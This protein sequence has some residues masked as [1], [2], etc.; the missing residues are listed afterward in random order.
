MG[1][2]PAKA[3]QP[4]GWSLPAELPAALR[5][6]KPYKL[7]QPIYNSLR[8][9]KNSIEQIPPIT[10]LHDAL[11]AH[12]SA[13]IAFHPHTLE[14]DNTERW[15]LYALPDA[16]L[17]TS[18]LPH[19]LRLWLTASYGKDRAQ[20]I[21][22]SW[23]VY[24]WD[25]QPLIDLQTADDRLKKMLLPGLVAR[26]IKEQAFQ[27]TLHGKSGTLSLP[28]NLVQ[29]MTE[30]GTA[31]LIS[32]PQPFGTAQGSFVL[33]F[34]IDVRPH[35]G[36][37]S[38]LYRLSVRRWVTE[39]LV[40]KNNHVLLPL[41]RNK[42]VYL[43]NTTRYLDHYPPERVYSRMHFRFVSYHGEKLRWIGHQAALF[44]QL[45]LD[46]I[47]TPMEL[48]ADPVAHSHRLL[49]TYNRE[50]EGL[51]K[52]PRL[53]T[54]L[55]ANDHRQTFEDL[56]AFLAPDF[57]PL[58]TGKR[59]DAGDGRVWRGRSL[60]QMRGRRSDKRLDA[61]RRLP[62]APRIELYVD[63]VETVQKILLQLL[64]ASTIA[65]QQGD[66]IQVMDGERLLL[67]VT[68]CRDEKLTQPLDNGTDIRNLIQKRRKELASRYQP[69]SPP[70]GALVVLQDY[71]KERQKKYD[72][73][74]AIRL[75]LADSGRVSQFLTP[76]TDEDTPVTRKNQTSYE[77]RVI[78]AVRDLLR[79]LGYRLNALYTPVAQL[80]L[81]TELDLVGF[82]VIQLNKRRPDQ[83][84]IKLPLMI[85]ALYQNPNFRITLPTTTGR[86]HDYPSLCEGL[87]AAAQ[88][89]QDYAGI[90]PEFFFREAF[91]R[92]NSQ[93]PTLLLLPEQNL[94]RFFPELDDQR[95]GPRI[96][97]GGLL[98]NQPHVRVARLRKSADLEAPYCVSTTKMSRYQG[99]YESELP[100]VFYSLHN[101]V[102]RAKLEDYKL[103][104]AH[105]SAA[106]PSTLQI[107]MNNLPVNESPAQ[108]AALVH[109]LRRESSH[110]DIPTILPQ[111]LHDALKVREYLLDAVFETD[112]EDDVEEN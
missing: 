14:R 63:D 53:E 110:T 112:D 84:T 13:I 68:V 48:L 103:D 2:P 34:W 31:E 66:H 12:S 46:P 56:S 104:K 42:S 72:P 15:W 107:Y 65:T 105:Q 52:R 40:G 88:L 64:G 90:T 54:G 92:R 91:F 74:Q 18:H 7:P 8:A 67:E 60:R 111:P 108:W 99:L 101:L 94:R 80:D 39:P 10:S 20:S 29:L 43:R 1:S 106:T 85:E 16:V 79:V 71:R 4:L 33:R 27:L 82:Y 23:G 77:L 37:L 86:V 36:E 50:P 6:V 35:T 102:R 76:N 38:L 25:D 81:P 21:I 49:I 109:R 95:S 30:R 11:A 9:L 97:L 32:E 57:K 24:E 69:T 83:E 17:K 62:S 100:D 28:L 73:K 93:R 5:Y 51:G 70:T 78:Q 96:S 55:H 26:W 3:V 59:V 22:E 98:D 47:P 61:L 41:H 44:D 58:P 87:I 19:F 75:G 45:Q 89:G